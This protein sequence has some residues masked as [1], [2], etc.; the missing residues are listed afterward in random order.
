MG[1]T[2][3]RVAKECKDDD[4]R[5]QMN[6]IKREFLGKRVVGL[7]ESVI[8]VLSM[9][10][11]Q[12]SHKVTQVNTNMKSDHVSLP[13]PKYKL[14][15]LDDDEE[16]VF[17][18]SMIDR[19]AARPKVLANMCLAEFAISYDPVASG[20]NGD[21]GVDCPNNLS[22]HDD[23]QFDVTDGRAQTLHTGR[24]CQKQETIKLRDGLGYMCKR[25]KQAI[26]RT[27]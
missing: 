1:E 6:K 11:M 26:L 17:T 2:L 20:F 3:K 27:R 15:E 7:P 8:C 25:K 23:Q 9:W 12:K 13:K 5:T 16:D 10:F 24:I 19:Y 14:C 21:D 18:T 22:G 4:I